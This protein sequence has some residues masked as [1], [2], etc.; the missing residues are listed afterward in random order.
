M[1]TRTLHLV[2]VAASFA[3]AALVGPAH[4]QQP[5]P[6][7]HFK[8]EGVRIG[9]ANEA[10][11]AFRQA[12]G[13]VVGYDYDLA[14]LVL[15]NIGI[16]NVSGVLVNFASLIPGL[17]ANRFDVIAAG[18]YIRKDRCPQV[19]F[20]DPILAVGNTLIVRKGNPRKLNSFADV[21]KDSSVKIGGTTGGLAK[22]A[23]D[24]GVPPAQIVE[25]TDWVS[26]IAALKGGRIEGALQTTVTARWTVKSS[27]DPTIEVA[28]PFQ[29]PLLNGQ[30]RLNYAGFAFAPEQEAL[31]NAF[32]NELKKVLGTPAHRKILDA[33][34]MTADEIPGSITL[35]EIC[36]R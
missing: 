27:N 1:W 11:F 34:G 24:D 13:S 16:G 5:L 29:Q 25:F 2:F 36:A 28:T 7:D 22:A 14:K 6:L 12:D 32:N 18:L 19:L 9:F 30:P 3:L 35:A 4:A 8:K 15:G 10:P 26:A 23:L 20:S 21:I 17:K 31:R 33:Y